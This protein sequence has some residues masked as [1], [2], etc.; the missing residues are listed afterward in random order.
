MTHSPWQ[1]ISGSRLELGEGLRIIDGTIRWVDLLRGQLYA[2]TPGSA[3]RAT[4]VHTFDAPLGFVEKAPDGR[5]IAA[6]G[7]GLS[8]LR[9]DGSITE[10]ASTGLN[11][12]RHRVNDGS[13][14]P[15]GSC[16]FGTMVHD[17]SPPDGHLWRW[18]PETGEVSALMSGIEIPNGP[19]FLPEIQA[20]LIGDTVAGV[21]LSKSLVPGS[22]ADPFLKVDGGSPDGMHVDRD[23]R[24]WNAV[25]GGHR[26]DVYEPGGRC[27][28]PLEL[29][30]S[31]PTSV[32]LI[33]SDDP[34]VI[35]TSASIGLDTPGPLDG[36]TIAAP[37]SLLALEPAR[38]R[39]LRRSSSSR[40]GHGTR[41]P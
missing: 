21:I 11:P 29:P 9:E 17:G 27:A 1:P 14:A 15:D 31:Q 6:L 4:L 35:V 38:V 28:K 34:L 2:W 10:I 32:T 39:G 25:W 40:K 16:W 3:D 18:D 13:F 33:A 41:A 8:W 37:L 20:M 30:V 22:S 26:L 5:L 24:L 23:G 19:I 36:F 12:S 7:T